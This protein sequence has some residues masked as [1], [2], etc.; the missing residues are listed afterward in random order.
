MSRI[1]KNEKYIGR[2]IWN[3]TET[4]RDPLTGRKRRVPKPE[5]EWDIR[6]DE[7]L[8]LVSEDLWQQVT[9]RWQEVDR[10]WPVRRRKKGAAGGHKT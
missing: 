10:V 4:R 6:E 2:W 3:R 7:D 9:K 1:L 8:R 5:S